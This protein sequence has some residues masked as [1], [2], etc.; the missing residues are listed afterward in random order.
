MKFNEFGE[1][2]AEE[3]SAPS[4]ISGFDEYGEP[5]RSGS[6]SVQARS[7]PVQQE[8]I[9]PEKPDNFLQDVEDA[10]PYVGPFVGGLY[11]LGV[12]AAQFG[13]SGTAGYLAGTYDAAKAGD[14]NKFP[15]TFM[16]VMEGAA[17]DPMLQPPTN[18][19]LWVQ[20]KIGEAFHW[21]EDK[22]VKAT[23]PIQDEL[24]A[25][26]TEVARIKS[27]LLETGR[28]AIPFMLPYAPKAVKY[29]AD[30]AKM[31]SKVKEQNL[32]A[33]MDAAEQA[34]VKGQLE[35][36]DAVRGEYARG[37]EQGPVVESTGVFGQSKTQ[38]G[39][40]DMPLAFTRE[41]I[42]DVKPI[43]PEGR[44]TISFQEFSQLYKAENKNASTNEL[45]NAWNDYKSEA[46]RGTYTKLKDSS[47][48]TQ[49]AQRAIQEGK[50][51]GV[52]PQ[53]FLN[54][55]NRRS[56][57]GIED[58]GVKEYTPLTMTRAEF[59]SAYAAKVNSGLTKVLNE[60]KALKDQLALL[61]EQVRVAKD[62]MRPE[63]IK[64]IELTNK[65][66]AGKNRT[67]RRVEQKLNVIKDQIDIAYN[68]Y[69]NNRIP[70]EQK[71]SYEGWKDKY[72]RAFDLRELEAAALRVFE[73]ESAWQAMEKSTGQSRTT[74]L[75]QKITEAFD[76]KKLEE[77]PKDVAI[78]AT[79]G[80]DTLRSS[81]ASGLDG[82]IAETR[83][84][85][86]KMAE[87]RGE[88]M[89]RMSLT[90][91][92]EPTKMLDYDHK[93]RVGL[94]EELGGIYSNGMKFEDFAGKLRQ[95]FPAMNDIIARAIFKQLSSSKAAP[96]KS[97]LNK[98]SGGKKPEPEK[99]E[100]TQ[101]KRGLGAAVAEGLSGKAI[102]MLIKKSELSPALREIVQRIFRLDMGNLKVG[103]INGVQ[104]FVAGQ[105]IAMGH[106]GG[107]LQGIYD[108]L[109]LNLGKGWFVGMKNMAPNWMN[110]WAGK[111]LPKNINDM[112]FYAANGR[113][114]KGTPFAILE[115]AK[116][117][118]KL[119]DEV[120]R[121]LKEA[122]LDVKY[123]ENHIARMWKPDM[124]RKNRDLFEQTLQKRGF[125]PTEIQDIVVSITE[126]G[127]MVAFPVVGGKV[128]MKQL[129]QEHAARL[130]SNAE[131][132]RKL[133]NLSVD[134][135]FPFVETN[136]HKVMASYIDQATKRGEWARKFGTREE[137]LDKLITDAQKELIEAGKPMSYQ[138][139]QRIYDIA[140][141]MQ[142]TYK[143]ISEPW[144]H[145][146]SKWPIS[147]SN[148][149]LLQL[150]TVASLPEILLP[151][152][153]GGV[154]AYA[155]ALPTAAK[156]MVKDFV[157]QNVYKGVSKTELQQFSE[158]IN[159]AGELASAERIMGMY[160]GTFAALDAFTFK[161]NLLHSWTKFVN[162]VAIETYRNQMKNMLGGWS[163][164]K[165]SMYDK[166]NE[167]MLNYYGLT[168]QEAMEWYK[169]GMPEQSP[170]FEKFKTGAVTFAEDFILTS[171][172]AIR[173]MWHSNPAFAMLAHLKGF[174]VM[175]GNTVLKRWFTD[176]AINLGEY[177]PFHRH[178]SY[179]IGVGAGMTL[180][181]M[182][183][184]MLT[185]YLRYGEK[186]NPNYQDEPAVSLIARG[187]ERVGLFGIG[188][189]LIDT[190]K[191]G[192]FEG[193][194]RPLVG[195]PAIG[196]YDDALT[197]AHGLVTWRSDRVSKALQDY[198]YAITVNL[199][200]MGIDVGQTEKKELQQFM[201][202]NLDKYLNMHS[203]RSLRDRILK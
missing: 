127:G 168:K 87:Q 4:A 50:S 103:E 12:L 62:P 38:P 153:G 30:Q 134:D 34:Q 49:E 188:G 105:R 194:V 141:A 110:G 57:P 111:S 91:K 182:L 165:P 125:T 113:P 3:S 145:N 160:G 68:K 43:A 76:G 42:P 79:R 102:S 23:G 85:L 39:S 104:S 177:T 149:A 121:Y 41:P 69:L 33:A 129:G 169:Q 140:D 146:I 154:K 36:A 70:W 163:K 143:L 94:H 144:K 29:A 55:S 82:I 71:I 65:Q 95:K 59:E 11:G 122:G 14:I 80:T 17:S 135:V 175:F 189:Q 60:Q 190:F 191:F 61:K 170:V 46:V 124:I 192:P 51:G 7:E 196:V 173:P 52:D 158:A 93:T 137:I 25:E 164:G 44:E 183:S 155:A 8:V 90:D 150:A 116:Q 202:D 63:L 174:P 109:Q 199:P 201:E 179:A 203:K 66:I 159:K 67:M 88:P 180:I 78:P 28:A 195:A 142:G 123:I 96:A 128:R 26:N 19:G 22:S 112:L 171:N 31:A 151:V 37:A 53:V 107:R 148:F 132:T 156:S 56:P 54:Q 172:P 75:A 187:M 5:I 133:Q 181:S 193:Y 152:Y 176:T 136:M 86:A 6:P 106:F 10:V 45:V 126:N 166:M 114:M 21:Y 13:L 97:K 162:Y 185:D 1:P 186:G 74:L 18:A 20:Q 115:A 77:S 117:I 40:P 15:S 139:V 200:R 92:Y 120:F 72:A 24:A 131:R 198:A 178:A 118:R 2:I 27:T 35:A 81:P 119:E 161:F 197:L 89:D 73:E 100:F 98:K 83:K 9:E 84:A 157:R 130:A 184:V 64:A 101:T 108:N 16:G 58:I 32:Q 167:R 48:F 138:E 47:I 99:L 147:I